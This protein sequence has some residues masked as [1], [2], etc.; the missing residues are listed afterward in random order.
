[1]RVR[2]AIPLFA[3]FICAASAVHAAAPAE[4]KTVASGKTQVVAS[5]GGREITL[6]E[7]RIEMNRIGASLND[8]NGERIALQSLINRTVLAK[9]ARDSNLHRKP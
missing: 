4:K 6:S 2:N 5:V 9:A 1:M 7:L 3:A 8:P